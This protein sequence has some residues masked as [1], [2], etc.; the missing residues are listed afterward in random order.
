MRPAP[1]LLG[2]PSPKCPLDEEGEEKRNAGLERRSN[3]CCQLIRAGLAC[4][5]KPGWVCGALSAG[6][7]QH[8]LPMLWD[9]CVCSQSRQLAQ[10]GE[11]P[12]LCCDPWHCPGFLEALELTAGVSCGGATR[13][14]CGSRGQ[15]L[16][17]PSPRVSM[18]T[19]GCFLPHAISFFS[20][21]ALSSCRRGV[22]F[23]IQPWKAAGKP[24]QVDDDQRRTRGR[25][26]VR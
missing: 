15:Q 2:A 24:V 4:L 8:A 5:D 16:E 11:I 6:R 9:F 26:K 23:Q 1:A 10:D 17:G 22:L 12:S 13:G 18:V 19:L 14:V 20:L 21:L 25:T 3:K 7:A